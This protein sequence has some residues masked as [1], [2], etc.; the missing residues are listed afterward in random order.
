VSDIPREI[1]TAAA[2]AIHD[3]GCPDR[4][5]SDAPLGHCYKLAR[6]ALEAAAPLIA[7]AERERQITLNQ[8]AVWR[9]AAA[10]VRAERE[11]LFAAVRR[12]LP[13]SAPWRGEALDLIYEVWRE[14]DG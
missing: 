3:T 1:L 9:Q 5:C 12:K 13:L 6:A 10:A 11:R 4:T 7:A 2:V 8:G 14:T